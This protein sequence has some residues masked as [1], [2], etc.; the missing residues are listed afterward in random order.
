MDAFF[1]AIIR[2]DESRVVAVRLISLLLDV[3]FGTGKYI[4]LE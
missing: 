4:L 2:K 1:K 3:L